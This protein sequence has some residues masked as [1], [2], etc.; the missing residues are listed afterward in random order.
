MFLLLRQSP[1][2]AQLQLGILGQIQRKLQRLK[3]I[4]II[5]VLR[6][7]EIKKV[8]GVGEGDAFCNLRYLQIWLPPPK[9]RIIN[10]HQQLKDV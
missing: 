2:P 5:D 10:S 9:S 6:I 1:L 4:G 3:F 7:G 8:P